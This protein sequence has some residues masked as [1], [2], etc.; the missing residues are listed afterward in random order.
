[1][2]SGRA[3]PAVCSTGPPAGPLRGDM[4]V[5]VAPPRDGRPGAGLVQSTINDNLVQLAH[6]LKA[7]P[8]TGSPEVVAEIEVSGYRYVLTRK[9]VDQAPR[10][11]AREREI[12]RLVA[13][14]MPNKAIGRVLD[15]SQWT[16]ASY[17]RR[18]FAKLGVT[19]RAEMV[20]VAVR[21][22]LLD[23]SVPVTTEQ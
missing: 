16:V 11:S 8:C 2:P 22:G 20:C 6:C 3:L 17:L 7:T 10:L 9:S 12:A 21:H 15:I 23:A 19:T 1:M 14:G 5:D 13:E 18:I 4:D